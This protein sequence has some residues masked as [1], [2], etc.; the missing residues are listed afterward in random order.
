[1][2]LYQNLAANW[3]SMNDN[4]DQ[5][6]AYK[7]TTTSACMNWKMLSAIMVGCNHDVSC[8]FTLICKD[9]GHKWSLLGNNKQRVTLNVDYHL[10]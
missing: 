9:N 3:I 8:I 4:L 5:Q 1:M 10:M 2:I 7:W 6:I